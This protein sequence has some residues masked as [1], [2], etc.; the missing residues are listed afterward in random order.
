MRDPSRAQALDCELVEGDLGDDAAIRR[1]LAGCD[2]VVRAAVYQVGVSGKEAAAMHEANVGGTERVL[3]A[4][5]ELG[6]PKA[7]HVS[8]I[9]V[10]GNT[11]G[12]A[13]DETS[14]PASPPLRSTTR[15]SARPTRSR[16]G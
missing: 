3:G 8:T 2:A 13:V 4:A 5:L 10:F 7:V 1:G 9:A 14:A 15:P 6:V 12:Q 16:A 11:D